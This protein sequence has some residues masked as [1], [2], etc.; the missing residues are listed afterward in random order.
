MSAGMLGNWYLYQVGGSVSRF[1]TGSRKRR[2]N[3]ALPCHTTTY[4]GLTF[5]PKIPCP[6]LVPGA[7]AQEAGDYRPADLVHKLVNR[8]VRITSYS[9]ST[10][11]C[12]KTFSRLPICR[13]SCANSSRVTIGRAP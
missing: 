2:E 5:H 6:D 10:M 4:A 9:T 1:Q 12:A 7:E 13:S 8:A 3:L 11:S